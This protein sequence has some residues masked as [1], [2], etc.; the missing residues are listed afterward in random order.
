MLNH[1]PSQ[2]PVKKRIELL[3]Q[4]LAGHS[5]ILLICVALLFLASYLVVA[6]TRIS[7]PFELDYMEGGHVAHVQ[8]ILDGKPL[9]DTPSLD[10]VAFCYSPL[11]F[12]VSSWLACVV[13][14]GFLPLRLVSLI[15]SLGCFAF[16]FLIV[17]RRTASLSASFVASCLYAATFYYSGRWFDLGHV[18]SLFVFFLLSG[19]YAFDSTNVIA[20]SIVSPALLFLSFFTK[21]PALVVAIGLSIAAFLTRRRFERYLFAM[22]F[23]L[24]VLGSFALMDGF[25]TQWYSYYV[26]ALPRQHGFS[27]P[28]IGLFWVEDLPRL[29]IALCFCYV[30][31]VA[32]CARNSKYDRIIQDI[33]IFGSLFLASYT[34]RL[35]IGSW[36]NVLMPLYAGVAIYFGVGLSHSLE[37]LGRIPWLRLL[38]IVAAV[39]Q[40]LNLFYLPQDQIPSLADREEGERLLNHI[41][42]IKGEVYW[43]DNPWYLHMLGRPMQSHVVGLVD[44]V[45]A[46]WSEEWKLKLEGEMRAAVTSG[47]YE[48]FVSDFRDF[49]LRVPEFD[50]YYELVDSNLTANSFH[51]ITHWDRKPTYLYLKRSTQH[52]TGLDVNKSGR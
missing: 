13:G 12:Y 43:A 15:S 1:F 25:R 49:T 33:L 3:M 19:L 2:G 11:Y 27:R 51:P 30:A 36:L 16:I 10:W 17:H 47:K 23:G 48:A 34:A 22:V 7:Y 29:G 52:D 9:Y 14:N 6:L 4:Y 26:F 41:G 32:V 31:F 37:R 45:R 21:Q 50:T 18:D 40:F 38:L 8:Q 35:H 20:R 24:L 39:L 28:R 5:Q 46:R 42:G 44:I